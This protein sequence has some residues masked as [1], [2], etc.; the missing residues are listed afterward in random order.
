[1]VEIAGVIATIQTAYGIAKSVVDGKID[2][3]VQAK[4]SEL[5]DSIINLQG[6]ILSLQS[7]NQDLLENNRQLKSQL[8]DLHQWEAI[9]G[10]YQLSEIS[11]GLFLYSLKDGSTE[12]HHYVCPNCF[13]KKQKSIL[14]VSSPNRTGSSYICPSPQCKGRFLDSTTAVE[15]EPPDFSGFVV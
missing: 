8:S 11:E 2:A 5:V 9:A 13:N 12:P 3:E 1:M 15:V 6:A 14:Q 10:S 7:E 4:A